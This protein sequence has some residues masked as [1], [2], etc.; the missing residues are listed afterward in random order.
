MASRTLDPDHSKQTAAIR[1]T[2]E[3]SPGGTISVERLF[4]NAV[5]H[6]RRALV[7]ADDS[8]RDAGLMV[9]F[10]RWQVEDICRT[11][12][13]ERRGRD[14]GMWNIAS[15]RITAAFEPIEKT[16]EN[17]D[18]DAE[19]RLDVFFAIQRVLC[20]LRDTLPSD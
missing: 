13:E 12:I 18:L 9:A 3:E 14:A 1:V 2:P 19:A 15:I 20:W 8:G 7:D 11:V 17:A 10:V 16:T 4:D 6:L 5:R